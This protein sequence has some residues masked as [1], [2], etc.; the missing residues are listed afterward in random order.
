[1]FNPKNTKIVSFDPLPRK[2]SVMYPSTQW[3][4]LWYHIPCK[5]S[6]HMVLPSSMYYL[7]HIGL[8]GLKMYLMYTQ[9]GN[10][11]F[12]GPFIVFPTFSEK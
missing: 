3:S 12:N 6:L 1:M 4:Y 9:V 5:V 11:S 2:R 10:T 7:D 8:I